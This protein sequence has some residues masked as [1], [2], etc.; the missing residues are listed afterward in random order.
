MLLALLLTHS[1]KESER[2]GRRR[3]AGEN[4]EKSCEEVVVGGKGEKERDE[5]GYSLERKGRRER[6][7]KWEWFS[8]LGFCALLYSSGFSEITG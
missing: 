3:N 6:E 7:G 5:G 2:G 1:S 4:G 8:F